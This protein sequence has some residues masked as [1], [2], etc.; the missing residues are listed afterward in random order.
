M[1]FSKAGTT[2]H[3]KY[4]DSSNLE[5]K[6]QNDKLYFKSII[7]FCLGCP[8]TTK[9]KSFSVHISFQ[10]PEYGFQILHLPFH[11]MMDCKLQFLTSEVY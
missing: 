2:F 8:L 1:N 3:H 4:S 5:T 7:S 10:S 6:S 11:H 9:P